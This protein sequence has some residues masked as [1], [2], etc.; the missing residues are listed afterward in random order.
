MTVAE[1]LRLAVA[2]G[3]TGGH[4]VPGLHLLAHAAARGLAVDALWLGAGRAVEE[5][6]FAAAGRGA[7]EGVRIERRALALEPAGGGAPSRVRLALG[8]PRALLVARRALRAHRAEV[9]LGLG[10]YTV[11]P[12]VLAARTLGLPVCLLE[13]NAAAGLATRWL[14]PLAR[15]VVHAWPSTV[16][17]GGGGR[18]RHRRLGPPLAPAFLAPVPDEGGRAAARAAL[19]FRPELPLLVVLGGS[20]GARGLNRFLAAEAGALVEGGLQVLH[21]VGPGRLA[22][23]AS[24][25]AGRGYRAVEYVDDV[26]GALDAA[27]LVLCRGG[28]STLA[29]VAARRVPALVVPYPHH[30]DRHQERNARAVGEGLRVVDE[31][32]LGPRTR[33]ELLELAAPGGARERAR[34]AALLGAAVPPDAALALLEELGELARGV[35]AA[36]STGPPGKLE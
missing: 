27:T 5:R 14:A 33:V 25:E 3:G 20:Q 2:G 12:A 16:P 24:L 15:R 19:G 6:V 23:A 34:R 30:G 1:P 26:R 21:Q 13:I 8:T 10:G 4:L 17:A 36:A 18:A 11:L 31:E 32:A 35:P 9:L 22:E 28:A 29:E 7:P